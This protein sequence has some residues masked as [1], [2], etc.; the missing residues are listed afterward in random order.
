MYFLLLT[1]EHIVAEI[2][3]REIFWDNHYILLLTLHVVASLNV[4]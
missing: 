2:K 1:I 3:D 4:Q